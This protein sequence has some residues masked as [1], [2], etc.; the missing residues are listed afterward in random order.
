[1][2]DMTDTQLAEAVSPRTP[3]EPA[4]PP[5]LRHPLTPPPLASQVQFPVGLT[6]LGNTCYMNATV[7]AL[8]AIP[9]LHTALNNFA[10]ANPA[11]AGQPDAAMTA[12]FRELYKDMRATSE[13]FPPLM[14]LSALR[15]VAPQFAERARDS[16]QYAQQDAQEAWGAIVAGLKGNLEKGAGGRAERFV[17]Q[18]LT[19]R[20]ETT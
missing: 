20:M 13:A 12:H 10:D 5:A 9:E 6:N 1:M 7:Q 15:Q 11:S 14:F 8:R 19:G 16:G 18:W 3:L 4:S 17:D 2:E